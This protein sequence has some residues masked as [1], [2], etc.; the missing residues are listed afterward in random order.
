M[1][2]GAMFKDMVNSE[3]RGTEN[4]N[5]RTEVDGKDI[6]IGVVPITY[7]TMYSIT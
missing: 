7:R 5:L 3:V 6:A 2:A 4:R 1:Y